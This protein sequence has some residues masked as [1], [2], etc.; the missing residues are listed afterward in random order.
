MQ[1]FFAINVSSYQVT[2]LMVS[3]YQATSLTFVNGNGDI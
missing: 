2:M 3:N 1:Y